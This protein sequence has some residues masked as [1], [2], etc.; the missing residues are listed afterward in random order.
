[1]AATFSP[2]VVFENVAGRILTD[3]GRFLRLH[4]KPKPRALADTQALLHYLADAMQ[5]YGWGTVLS[6]QTEMLP[7]SA[8]EQ[9]WVT[10][11]WLPHAVREAGYHACAILVSANLYTRLATAFVTNNVQSLSIRYR[12]FDNEAEAAAWLRKQ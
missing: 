9:A 12:S 6:N 8:E 10:S 7:L 2:A 3:Q 5:Q 11:T 1:M 4:W